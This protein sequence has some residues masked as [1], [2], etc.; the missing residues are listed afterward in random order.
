[1][2]KR[3]NSLDSKVNYTLYIIIFGFAEFVIK[4]G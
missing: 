3:F 4:G 1:M 2:D